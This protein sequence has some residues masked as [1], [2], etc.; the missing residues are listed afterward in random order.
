MDIW[1]IWMSGIMHSTKSHIHL[2][3][4]AAEGEGEEL[5]EFIQKWSP[6]IAY[7]SCVCRAGAVGEGSVCHNYCCSL[8]IYPKPYSYECLGKGSRW[9]EG[10]GELG[11]THSFSQTI[12]SKCTH[13]HWN[14]VGSDLLTCVEISHLCG[15]PLPTTCLSPP[16][17]QWLPFDSIKS[18]Y[19]CWPNCFNVQRK[20]S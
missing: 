14:V 5:S 16:H 10:A 6:K 9:V 15:A 19:K 4:S 7:G 18:V 13:T 17:S 8:V 20:F 12:I 3:L 11:A 2:P 1:H